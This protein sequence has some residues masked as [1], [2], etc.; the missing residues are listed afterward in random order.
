[1]NEKQVVEETKKFV[2]EKLMGEGSGHDWYHVERVYN[3]ALKIAKYEIGVDIFI[4]ELGALLHD[5]ADH[6]FGYSDKDRSRI[7]SQFLSSMNVN[8]KIIESIVYIANYISFKSG[9]NTHKMK[10]LEGRI[11]QDADRL[12]AMGAIG[13]GRAFAYGGFKN[14]IMYDVEGISDTGDTVSHFYEKLLLLKD[15]MNTDYGR[16][17]A[18]K[19]HNFMEEFLIKFYSEWKSE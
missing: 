2:K 12:D 3:N 11:V 5:I 9:K 8:Q 18:L 19:R 6:K 15:R 4:V 7:I 10:T 17:E 1:M 13:I 14:R 16:E